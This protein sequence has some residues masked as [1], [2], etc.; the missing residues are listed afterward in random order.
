MMPRLRRTGDEQQRRVLA[1]I[2]LLW[3]GLGHIQGSLTGLSHAELRELY[4]ANKERFR[5]TKF[6]HGWAFW[7]FEPGIPDELRPN[8]DDDDQ[9]VDDL[10]SWGPS[11]ERDQE[12]ERQRAAWLVLHEVSA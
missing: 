8:D 7:E 9:R 3:M 10:D 11:I 2:E 1:P 4:F 5:D 12:Q 6:E